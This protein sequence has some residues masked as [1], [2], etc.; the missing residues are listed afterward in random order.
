[1][2]LKAR[3]ILDKAFI[4]AVKSLEPDNTPN[5]VGK[6]DDH[7]I[8]VTFTF[9]RI[10]SAIEAI[11]DYLSNLKIATEIEEANIS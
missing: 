9:D 10:G 7:E 5:I 3:L 8:S 2:K 6:T 11:D 1:M 4:T